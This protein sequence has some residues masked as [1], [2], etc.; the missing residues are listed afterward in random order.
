MFGLDP[1]L[2]KKDVL[3]ERWKISLEEHIIDLAWSRDDRYLAAATVDGHVF[4]IDCD[5]R[6]AS[7]KKVGGHSLGANSISW[8]NDG[9]Q[10][11][12]AG[13]DGKVRVWS[14]ETGELLHTIE[15]GSNWVAKA[16][17]HPRL[18]LVAI[19]TGRTLKCWDETAGIVYESSDHASTIADASWNPDGSFVAVAAYNG[20]TLHDPFNHALPRKFHWKGSSLL[21]AWSPD[22]KYIATGEQDSTVHFWFVES[23]TDAQMWGFATKVMEIS[24]HSSGRWLA[25]GGGNEICIWD[26]G[27]SGPAGREPVFLR[28][29]FNKITQLAY[30]PS[31]RYLVS[32]DVDKFLL[33]WEPEMHNQLISAASLSAPASCVRWNFAGTAL[34]TGQQDG[35]ITAFK[36][37]NA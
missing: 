29:H 15:T 17:Y 10:F 19:A 4:L 23:G 37:K 8:R 12:S 32:T 2:F 9:Q 22:A 25:T 24:W 34:A 27:G 16:A 28:C 1:V 33:L 3:T 14:A 13:Q 7:I 18:P 11:A 35:V 6:S 31:G 36:V 26:C 20:V 30:Q 21:L 5:D